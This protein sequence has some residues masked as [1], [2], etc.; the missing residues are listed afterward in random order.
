VLDASA[1]GGGVLLLQSFKAFK[2]TPA[3]GWWGARMFVSAGLL[4]GLSEEQQQQQR[5][6]QTFDEDL[7]VRGGSAGGGG[8]GQQG[9]G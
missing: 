4:E 1:A 8:R 6:R 3:S 5:Q 9:A 2:A 7:Q